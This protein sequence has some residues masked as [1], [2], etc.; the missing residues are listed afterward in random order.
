VNVQEI[1]LLYDYNCWANGRI[2]SAA[3]RLPPEQFG[4]ARLGYCHLP[5]TLAHVFGA[6]RRWRLRW[7]GEP[8]AALPAPEEMSTLPTLQERWAAEQQLVRLYLSTL[9]NAE[10]SEKFSYLTPKGRSIT[11]TRWHT[12][13]HMINHGTQHRAELAMLLTELGFSPGNLDLNVF[14]SES[15]GVGRGAGKA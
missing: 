6:E 7:Q 8:N 4:A 1:Q 2:L 12:I 10:L 14:L 13:V 11:S 15:Q 9:R 3:A 5:D